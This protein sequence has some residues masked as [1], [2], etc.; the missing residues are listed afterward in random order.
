MTTQKFKEHIAVLC[1]REYGFNNRAG[2]ISHCLSPKKED[3]ILENFSTDMQNLKREKKG[4]SLRH[5]KIH[6]YMSNSNN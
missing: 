2:D 1:L 4:Q 3:C 6:A 5:P